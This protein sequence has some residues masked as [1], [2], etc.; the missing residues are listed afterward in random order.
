M[1]TPA[2]GVKDP[3]MLEPESIFKSPNLT[4]SL[5]RKEELSLRRLKALAGHT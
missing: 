4:P 2:V 1:K 5:H 3:E